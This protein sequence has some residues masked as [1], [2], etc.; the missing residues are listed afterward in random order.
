[1]KKSLAA[2]TLAALVGLSLGFSVQAEAKGFRGGSS[3]RSYSSPKPAP[4]VVQKQNV[5]VNKTV[6][7]RTTV[8]QQAPASSGGSGFFG[9]MFGSFLGGAAGAAVGNALTQPDPAPQAAP[10][11]CDPRVYDC[12]VK[13]QAPA[14]K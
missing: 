6:V 3:F 14:A 1:M 2:I 7:N 4:R 9:T 5:T 11:Q 8:V 10:P 12:S 13:P